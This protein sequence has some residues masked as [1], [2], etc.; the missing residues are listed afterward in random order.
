MVSEPLRRVSWFLVKRW[1][2]LIAKHVFFRLPIH[3]FCW[4]RPLNQIE[5]ADAISGKLWFQTY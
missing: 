1:N 4:V 5:R 3:A 2:K